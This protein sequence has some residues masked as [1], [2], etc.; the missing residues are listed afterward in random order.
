MP[1][2]PS[3]SHRN[4]TEREGRWAE[5]HPCMPWSS[6][7]IGYICTAIGVPLITFATTQVNIGNEIHLRP[8]PSPKSRTKYPTTPRTRTNVGKNVGACG[9]IAN[10]H[11][12]TR[13]LLCRGWKA[14]PEFRIGGH[15]PCLWVGFKAGES[16]MGGGCGSGWDGARDAE[17]PCRTWVVRRWTSQSPHRT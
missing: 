5:G 16:E 8:S 6:N 13:P 15:T 1:S 14:L 3:F 10:I 11:T 12:P 9:S 2:Q 17:G 7:V 4:Q